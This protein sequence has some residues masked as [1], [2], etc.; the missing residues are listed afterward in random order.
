MLPLLGTGAIRA[1]IAL[2]ILASF[3][4]YLTALH[5]S[6]S[7]AGFTAALI[8]VFGGIEEPWH[9]AWLRVLYTLLG[10][11]VAFAVGVLIW[12][13]HAREALRNKMANIL[14]EIGRAS[15]TER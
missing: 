14:Q 10:A 8:L 6:F 11:V 12:P 15:C 1:G 9:V 5:P 4:A 7:A 3:F 2:F 13:V